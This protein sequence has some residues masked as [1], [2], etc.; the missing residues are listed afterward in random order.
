MS[1]DILKSNFF[2]LF[3][4]PVSYDVDLNQ[5]RAGMAPALELSE[6]SA[7]RLRILAAKQR[8][9]LAAQEA[10]CARDPGGVYPF[11]LAD[12]ETL[13]HDCWLSPIGVGGPLL[14]ADALPQPASLPCRIG[15]K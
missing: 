15:L 5:I 8:E 10:F 14:T 12:A 1:K 13:M 9:A 2:E 4:L 6:H 3:Q 11:T 7:I